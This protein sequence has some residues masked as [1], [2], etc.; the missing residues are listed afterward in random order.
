MI[1]ARWSCPSSAEYSDDHAALESEI[2]PADVVAAV[3]DRQIDED[4]AAGARCI[5]AGEDL[6]VGEIAQTVRHHRAAARDVELESQLTAGVW[7]VGD[8][9]DDPASSITGAIFSS[10]A[11]N[12]LGSV[13]DAPTMKRS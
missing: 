9:P 4:L 3:V 1:A 7:V 2:D 13:V 5:G 12:G 11:S 10:A 8:D 6:T